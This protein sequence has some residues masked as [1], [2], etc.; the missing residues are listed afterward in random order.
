MDA[1]FIV[2]IARTGSS[3]LQSMLNAHPDVDIVNELHFRAPR[4]IRKDVMRHVAEL[5]S[6]Q[7][8]ERVDAL[9]NLLF[10]DEL[11]GTFWRAAEQSERGVTVM[12]RQA[13]RASILDS[14]RSPEALLRAILAEHARRSGARIPGAKFPVEISWTPWLEVASP[15]CRLIHVTRDPRA[16]YPS[17]V[18]VEA[19]FA[20]AQLGRL[21]EPR[22]RLRRLV[23][24][25]D[26]YRKAAALHRRYA[27]RSCYL[28]SRFEDLVSDPRSQLERICAFLDLE[29]T[30]EMLHPPVR[31]SSYGLAD[32]TVRE[33]GVDARTLERWKELVSP[34]AQRLLMAALASSM[35]TLG[36]RRS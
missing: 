4:W 12:D 1:V 21:A 16:I 29:P 23:Y 6:M 35:E 9:V 3:M 33:H 8:D 17:M 34:S 32:H 36:Y 26:Q 24:I 11:G 18:K 25:V 14:D 5:G 7:R 27:H 15:G 30:Q 20:P 31:N 13:L 28:Q 22:A 19:H 10:A 2:G